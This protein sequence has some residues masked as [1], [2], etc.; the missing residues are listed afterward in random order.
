LLVPKIIRYI[1][2]ALWPDDPTLRQER[3][4]LTVSGVVLAAAWPPLPLG[5]LAFAALIFPLD[6]ISGKPF[7]KA[8]KSGYLFSF[9]YFICSLYWIGWVHVPGTVAAVAIISAY[10]A[11]IFALYAA[12]YR[13]RRMIGII[14]FPF[15]WV[16]MEYFR[17]L[18]EI[19]FPWSNLSYTQEKYTPFL[20]VCEYVGDMGISFI[21]VVVNILLWR[22]WRNRRPTVKAAMV[23]VAGLLVVLPS[24]YGA[25]VLSG[26]GPVGTGAIEIALLQGSIP[27]DIKWHN[28]SLDHNLRVYDSLATAAA[29][30]DL[31]VWPE[32]AVPAYLLAD[33]RRTKAVASIAAKIR[34]P[35]LVGTLDYERIGDTGLRTYNA[36]IQFDPDGRHRKPYHKNKLVPFAETV[37]YGQYIPFLANLSLGWSDF[38]HGRELRLYDNSYGSYGTLICYEV[39]FPEMVNRYVK[40]GADFL[41]NITNDTWYGYSSGPY[42]HAGMAVFRAIE[43]RIWIARAANSGFSY[44]VDRYGR[45]YNK[46]RLFERT[47][48]RGFVDPIAGRTVFNRTG[49]VLGRAGLL[50]I[51]LVTCILMVIWIRERLFH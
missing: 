12:V 48:V 28:D 50:I 45:V 35:M 47:V 11:F 33:Y 9:V 3:F 20:Q 39:I 37:P 6:T 18:F 34:S 17:S 46:S 1:R 44:F 38:E 27:L 41:V 23:A 4:V 30:A 8:F 40:G 10:S 31:L 43:N 25:R 42:Q 29:P 15:L 19:A 49:P 51:G 13:R 14:L 32:T 24:L 22:A 7:G 5:F 16:G 2:G 36:A 26:A 21:I